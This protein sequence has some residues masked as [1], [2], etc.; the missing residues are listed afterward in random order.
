MLLA[1]LG[2]V[3]IA[4]QASMACNALARCTAK[5]G[6]R[7]MNPSKLSTVAAGGRT[8]RHQWRVAGGVAGASWA[9]LATH[10]V[11]ALLVPLAPA[12]QSNP[13]AVLRQ[14]Y[15]NEARPCLRRSSQPYQ[16]QAV[17]S[18]RSTGASHTDRHESPATESRGRER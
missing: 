10:Q 12:L 9:L 4:E 13:A 14:Q 17:P 6:L 3:A 11:H 16:K 2:G 18:S 7:P 5:P 1:L 15:N 8:H